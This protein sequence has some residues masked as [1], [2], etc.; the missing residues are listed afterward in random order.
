M[1]KYLNFQEKSQEKSEET[2]DI[3]LKTCYLATKDRDRSI[4][5]GLWPRFQVAKIYFESGLLHRKSMFGYDN[6]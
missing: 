3:C 6:E 1:E 4:T 5:P 2:N